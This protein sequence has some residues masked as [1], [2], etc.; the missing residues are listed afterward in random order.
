MPSLPVNATAHGLSS[1]VA[2]IPPSTRSIGRPPAPAPAGCA[3]AM[4]SVGRASDV[5]ITIAHTEMRD[6][7]RR[8]VLAADATVATRPTTSPPPVQCRLLG[9]QV[10]GG[11][12]VVI[13][14]YGSHE[15]ELTQ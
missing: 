12:T 3:T 8:T 4:A 10:P 1:V 11:S 13:T 9:R 14:R 7:A 15:A 5:A 6:S 2:G